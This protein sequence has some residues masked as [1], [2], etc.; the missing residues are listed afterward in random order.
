MYSPNVFTVDVAGM[1][2]GA[3]DLSKFEPNTRY[4]HWIDLTVF[5]Q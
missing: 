3:A 5:A 1:M 4:F 2:S